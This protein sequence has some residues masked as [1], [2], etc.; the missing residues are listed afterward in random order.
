MA[1]DPRHLPVQLRRMTRSRKLVRR[2]SLALALVAVLLLSSFDRAPVSGP[3]E[4]GLP[5]IRAT[6]PD[7][8]SRLEALSRRDPKASSGALLAYA[9]RLPAGLPRLRALMLAA[10]GFARTRDEAGVDRVVGKIAAELREVAWAEPAS[11]LV[12]AQWL[13]FH[14]DVHKAEN[15][16]IQASPLVRDDAPAW[17]RLRLLMSYADVC[18]R[19]GR[20]DEALARYDTAMKLADAV[21]P[22]WR[23]ID[24][25]SAMSDMMLQAGRAETAA[26]LNEEAMVLAARAGD[27]IGLSDAYT[28]RAMLS[29]GKDD[30]AT[31]AAWQAAI[32]HARRAGSR[33][34]WVLGLANIADYYLEHGDYA[35]AHATAEQA[36]VMARELG[37]EAATSVALANVGLAL[38][39]MHRRAEGLPLVQESI[40]ID[41]RTGTAMDGADNQLELGT[42]LERAGY[43]DDALQAY[44][45]YRAK[46]DD[47]QL[48]DRDRALVDT[49]ESIDNERRKYELDLLARQSALKEALIRQHALQI[50]AWSSAV[51]AGLLLVC[52]CAMLA[53]HLRAKNRLLRSGNEM[54]RL[55][56]E[57]DP[58][59]GVSNRRHLTESI[60]ERN[61]GRIAGALYLIDLDHFRQINQNHGHAGGDTA[62][63]EV[64]RRFREQ[65]REDDLL[66]RWGGEEFVIV[67]H[68]MGR[69]AARALAGRLL[70]ALADEPILL[71]GHAVRVTASIGY[72]SVAGHE[73]G[74]PSS[75]GGPPVRPVRLE[76]AITVADAAMYQMKE[77]GRNGAC[78]VFP[79]GNFGDA[80]AQEIALSLERAALDG[81]IEMDVLHHQGELHG[82]DPRARPSAFAPLAS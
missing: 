75:A 12:R 59:T 73:D 28:T 57:R 18:S 25:R 62:L 46:V 60:A 69:E 65:L 54:L 37:D 22:S 68:D 15:L 31:I 45:K 52:V 36:L 2:T 24:V 47:L 16:L 72:L 76:D 42:Y 67:V 21:G 39:S 3:A 41:E 8:F 43:L 70:H 49:E 27:E 11:L 20:Y 82:L 7:E 78:G 77:R 9:D 71:G 35:T 29:D 80:E 17:L 66:C 58:L 40:D 56:A 74:E 34:Q 38:I 33:P 6:A 26:R 61:G 32:D 48:R 19:Q 44:R 23:S 64:A 1:T 10:G 30:A 63:V 50:R 79:A 5:P 81:R 55:Q 4:A 53:R 14:G 13:D 51:L